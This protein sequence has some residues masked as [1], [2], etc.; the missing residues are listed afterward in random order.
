MAACGRAS[1]IATCR[2]NPSR[3][4]RS[5]R[6]LLPA[7]GLQDLPPK[8][9]EKPNTS[10]LPLTPGRGHFY[11]AEKRTFLLCVDTNPQTGLKVV[12]NGKRSRVTN[13]SDNEDCR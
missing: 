13:I 3:R 5:W 12:C 10:P 6:R 2:C 11:L 1:A 7:Y 8:P 4:L 9:E